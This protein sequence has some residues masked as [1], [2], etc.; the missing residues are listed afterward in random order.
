[1][2][3]VDGYYYTP[4]K[5]HRF[6]KFLFF[7]FIVLVILCVIYWDKVYFFANLLLGNL[8]IVK[9]SVDKEN[10]FL[11]RGI[12]QELN[13][14]IRASA[15][16]FCTSECR[17]RLFDLSTGEKIDDSSLIIKL[18][19][20]QYKTYNINVDQAGAGQKLYRFQV[21]CKSYGNSLCN[22]NG[23]T[24]ERSVIV[25]ANYGPSKEYELV[26]NTTKDRLI[27]L[28][29]NA[30]NMYA[31]L[32]ISTIL[33]D[34]FSDNMAE[35]RMLKD[36]IDGSSSA[37]LS[38][39][40][41]LN[42]IKEKWESSSY[43]NIN[44]EINRA[45]AELEV[46]RQRYNIIM[47]SLK[48][49]VS[50]HNYL[51][52]RIGGLNEALVSIKQNS[53]SSANS[54]Q[55]KENI[56]K[57]NDL[58]SS[59]N[60]PYNLSNRVDEADRIY[61]KVQKLSNLESEESGVIVNDEIL[62]W[63]N[64]RLELVSTNFSYYPNLGEPKKQCCLYGQC[65]QCCDNSC[66]N[67]PSKYPIIL[68]HG[69]DF[70][71]RASAEA[72]LDTFT[73]IQNMLD[74]DGYI[75]AGSILLGEVNSD[76]YGSLGLINK[77][78]SVKAS[79]YFDLYKNT[80]SSVVIQTKTD[81]IDTYA[82]RLRDIIDTVKLKTG[83]DKVIIIAHSMG[84]LVVRRYNDIF[85]REDIHKLILLGTP[86]HGIEGNILTYCSIIGAKSECEDM[87]KDSLF[88]N[89]LSSQEGNEII[90]NIIG[91]GCNM[92]EGITGDGI[93]TNQSA[94]LPGANNFY[95]EG[96]CADNLNMLHGGLL[97][98][99]IYPRVYSIINETLGNSIK[100]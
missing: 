9:V 32:Y 21:D 97:R 95:I 48:A 70:N 78:I 82:I 22:T 83:R 36:S 52:A 13:F 74:E 77:S 14:Q 11:S 33:N 60:K 45:D 100:N 35:K 27:Y 26:K 19:D 3:E 71:S 6:R 88:I 69:H 41:S 50:A 58:I 18:P 39:N 80:K 75:N 81:S 30:S 47:G 92:G 23:Q 98:P 89:K 99:G 49:N 62:P 84:G 87:D 59:L 79:Y 63:K 12:S 68:L 17:T 37:L 46:F 96:T 90:Y 43:D 55:L 44:D 91:V 28:W 20:P 57:Y 1:M 10:V 42:F 93:V 8:Y 66:K 85:S 34:K 54:L 24:K 61:S 64:D 72:S 25:T 5:R 73:S 67:D 31:N 53:L 51:I 29:T 16:P 40:N 2:G 15:N 4:R 56:A 76:D 94:Y 86:N 7:V 38:F 65:G